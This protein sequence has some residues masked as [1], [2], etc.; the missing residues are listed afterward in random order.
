LAGS[1][2]N[3]GNVV[4]L[5]RGEPPRAIDRPAPLETATVLPGAA[6]IDFQ[7]VSST[8]R[9]LVLDTAGNQ[10]SCLIKDI[11]GKELA[12]EVFATALAVALRLPL[13]VCFLTWCPAGMLPGVDP[14]DDTDRLVFSSELKDQPSIYHRFG[15][16]L[17]KFVREKIHAWP[18]YGA[19]FS[20]DTW[21]A[22][23]D[24]HAGNLLID[25]AGEIWLID[26]G[27]ALTGP[28]WKPSDLVSN[29][30]FRN[31]FADWVPPAA[32]TPGS[33]RIFDASLA[34]LCKALSACDVDH[35]A[36]VN[37]LA[38]LIE[39]RDVDAA[40]AFLKARHAETDRLSRQAAGQ[41]I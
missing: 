13:P 16:P 5:K 14:S 3:L 36:E 37:R 30:R 38:D 28:D 20:F 26:H 34:G 21:V 39:K 27:Y 35:A 7:N 24:R 8:Y 2:E 29:A 4:P 32:M 31:R 22:N 6:R 40:L 15:H 17:P 18:D 9:G 12:N 23:I 10:R 41:V 19:A 33:R 25:G 11:R 1:D